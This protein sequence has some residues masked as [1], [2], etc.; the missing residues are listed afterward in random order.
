M[1]AV[2]EHDQGGGVDAAVL[3]RK[4]K[5]DESGQGRAHRPVGGLDEGEGRRRRVEDQG[6][7]VQKVAVEGL[8][9]HVGTALGD[10]V[11]DGHRQRAV[12]HAA[13]LERAVV[14]HL[15]GEPT[16]L[17]RPH[18]DL[19]GDLGAEGRPLRSGVH[20]RPEDGPGDGG[21]R[22]QRHDDLG[23][24]VRRHDAGR[25][26]IEGESS[27]PLTQRDA[28]LAG[29]D[30]GQLE[31]PV[32]PG[33][34]RAPAGERDAAE[35]EP[36]GDAGGV[37]LVGRQRLA[38]DGPHALEDD[39]HRHDLR[40]AHLHRLAGPVDAA[41]DVDG[42][43]GGSHWHP[44]ELEEA[45][46]GPGGGLLPPAASTAHGELHQR[47]RRRDLLAPCPPD[48]PG[49]GAGLA[50]G[51]VDLHGAVVAFQ[52]ARGGAGQEA[53]GEAGGDGHLALGH[54]FDGVGPVPR[55]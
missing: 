42:E 32:G 38:A 39:L 41:Q 43:G 26:A 54:A 20:A 22:L 50:E 5:D 16:A 3:V 17:A 33:L 52:G 12:G 34:D 8:G 31:G 35:G 18:L 25:G 24:G 45:V 10:R 29:Q 47:R 2:P 51:D 1:V 21:A 53:A 19:E 30:L 4:L 23:L 9:G 49:D 46:L 55:G 40:G 44:G 11:V 14:L 36:A 13:G 48:V 37:G 6:A 15:D 7:E 28:E 27:G